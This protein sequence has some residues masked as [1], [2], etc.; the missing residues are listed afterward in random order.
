MNTTTRTLTIV[1][2]VF[3]ILGALATGIILFAMIAVS[4]DADAI[5][6][7]AVDSGITIAQVREFLQAFN[8]FAIVTLSLTALLLVLAIVLLIK[9]SGAVGTNIGLLVL[10][11]LDVN[12][13]YL[14][15]SI[16]GFANQ[17]QSQSVDY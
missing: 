2:L 9:G 13:F 4:N 3:H 1:G 8:I 10:A 17:G 16:I 12:I 7:I 11:I 15:A 14:I 5:A 6:K